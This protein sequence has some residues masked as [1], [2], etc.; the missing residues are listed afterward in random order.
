MEVI[1]VKC[2]GLDV[3][4]KT[5]VACVRIAVKSK[6]VRAVRTFRATTSEWLALSDGLSS[7]GCTHVAMESTG[8]YWKPVWQV[9][10]GG[11]E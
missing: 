10:E 8:V 6:V 4:Q 2:A 9:L 5:V 7:H 1:H 11:L 3:H